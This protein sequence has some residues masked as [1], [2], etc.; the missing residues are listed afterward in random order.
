[1]KHNTVVEMTR[2]RLN[3]DYSLH[4]VVYWVGKVLRYLEIERTAQQKVA[5]YNYIMDNKV[6][7]KQFYKQQSF[8]RVAITDKTIRGNKMQVNNIVNNNGNTVA[9]QFSINDKG[10]QYF[11]SYKTIIVKIDKA[12]N[13]SLDRNYWDYSVTTSKHRNI[14][15]NTNTKDTKAKIKSGE[16]KLTDLNKQGIL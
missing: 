10:I 12:G 3:N 7:T 14:F 11:Q 2:A 9:N 5:L 16:Y 1:M 8:E 13:I 4:N 6:L 15:L